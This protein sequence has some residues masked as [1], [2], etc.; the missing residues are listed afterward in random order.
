M[1]NLSLFL[2]DLNI[3]EIE[4]IIKCSITKFFE[5]EV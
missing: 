5:I 4:S 3:L 2:D 1:T